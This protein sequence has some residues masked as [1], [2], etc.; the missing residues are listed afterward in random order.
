MHDVVGGLVVLS[1]ELQQVSLDLLLYM[2][3]AAGHNRCFNVALLESVEV[4][5]LWR[6][7][8]ELEH[9]EV[10]FLAQLNQVSELLGSDD[11]LIDCLIIDF[12]SYYKP[13]CLDES[14]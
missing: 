11:L 10:L 8:N 1:L 3:V 2:I 5:V 6:L 7:G 12:L 14:I 9:V 4:R 13:L